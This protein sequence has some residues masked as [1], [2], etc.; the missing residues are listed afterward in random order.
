MESKKGPLGPVTKG[1]SLTLEVDWLSLFFLLL[2][3]C[4]I[5]ESHVHPNAPALTPLQGKSL[6]NG[7][8]FWIISEG[9][10][11]QNDIIGKGTS[12]RH[13]EEVVQGNWGFFFKKRQLSRSFINYSWQI[14][15]QLLSSWD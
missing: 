10:K 7:M 3:F 12:V 8:A 4:D 13:I 9:I 2:K 5:D 14:Q 1:Q 15:F 11:N 6:H